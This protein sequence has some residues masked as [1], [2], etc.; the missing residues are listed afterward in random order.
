MAVY[1][2][3]TILNPKG[4]FLTWCA[5]KKARWYLNK[6]R[7]KLV[8]Q[9]KDGRLTIQLEFE[10]KGPGVIDN[11]YY[12]EPKENKCVVCGTTDDLTRHHVVPR[13]YR[14]H[15]P[16]DVKSF[17]SHDVL[18][19]CHE[20]HEKYEASADLFKVELLAEVDIKE[21]DI[22]RINSLI[23]AASSYLSTNIRSR[24]GSANFNRLKEYF[25]TSNFNRSDLEELANLKIDKHSYVVSNI[26]SVEHFCQ[27]W[28][29]HFVKYAKPQYLPK[30]WTVEGT[31]C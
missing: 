20:C 25:G 13:C 30:Y 6:G 3:C 10:P 27:R 28:R 5:S 24:K 1:D 4:E 19:V 18:A 29:E 11:P 16:N 7:A 22:L 26:E 2:G 23:K 31:W 17:A 8:D 15:F 9:D 14:K 21:E 12:R